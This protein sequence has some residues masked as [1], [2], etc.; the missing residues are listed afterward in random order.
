MVLCTAPCGCCPLFVSVLAIACC[1]HPGGHVYDDMQ[2]LQLQPLRIPPL[3]QP[4]PAASYLEPC[5]LCCLDGSHQLL[6]ATHPAEQTVNTQAEK[7]TMV[8]VLRAVGPVLCDNITF[9]RA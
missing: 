7:C 8:P 5:L 6:A 2:P 9:E 1:H 3:P 4:R